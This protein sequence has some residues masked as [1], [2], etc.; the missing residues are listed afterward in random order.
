MQRKPLEALADLDQ[1]V[2]LETSD[3]TPVLADDQFERGR[4]LHAQKDFAAAL[5]AFD[6]AL[7]MRPRDARVC[8]LRAETLLELNRLPE[9][10]QSLN[11]CVKFGVP[12]AGAFRA[13]AT[14][15]IRLGQYANAQTDYTRALELDANATTYAARGW[16]FLVADAPK[17]AL[18]DFEESIRRVPDQSD[19]FAGRGLCRVLLGETQPAIADAEEALRQGPESTRLFYNVTRI[20]AQ[21]VGPL[22]RSSARASAGS[23][24]VRNC[25]ERAVQTLTQTLAA[26][27]AAEATQFW[28][29][30]V[31]T[32][33]ALNSIRQTAAFRQLA[34]RYSLTQTGRTT[35]LSFETDHQ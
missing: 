16:C 25:Q 32:D 34:T 6:Q 2:R 7:H 31:A 18:S 22:S 9:A 24:S 10:L 8:R 19:A 11:D 28:Q 12:D 27:T 23:P 26:Q 15:R 21:A 5:A 3:A 33:P 4:I 14:L 17:L 30:I 1:V 20:Y 35:G 13:R 29:T